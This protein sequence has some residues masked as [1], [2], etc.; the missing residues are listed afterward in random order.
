MMNTA[1]RTATR[2]RKLQLNRHVPGP[3]TR[4]SKTSFDFCE[5][6]VEN[7]LKNQIDHGVEIEYA[8]RESQCENLK[9][10]SGGEE[11]YG[12]VRRRSVTVVSRCAKKMSRE[13]FRRMV[14]DF[15]ARQ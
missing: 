2:E 5:E 14:E 4:N 10:E 9:R 7:S 1:T 12:G 11:R 8:R 6:Y 3:I 13:E 15:I